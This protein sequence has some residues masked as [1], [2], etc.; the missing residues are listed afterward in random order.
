VTKTETVKK[1]ENWTSKMRDRRTA[2]ETE[3]EL[4]KLKSKGEISG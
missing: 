3:E 1:E 4:G 2:N